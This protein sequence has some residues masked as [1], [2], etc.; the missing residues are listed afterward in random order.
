MFVRWYVR[1][2]L[3]EP[4]RSRV[5]GQFLVAPEDRVPALEHVPDEQPA[6]L[7]EPVDLA[8][9]RLA[10]GA[11]EMLEDAALDDDVERRVRPRH[12]GDRPFHER[13]HAVGRKCFA[14][15]LQRRR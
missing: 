12:V 3:L 6:R 7:H 1:A 10:V 11:R 5:V 9:R 4:Q 8:E 15:Q 14:T 13:L 2:A